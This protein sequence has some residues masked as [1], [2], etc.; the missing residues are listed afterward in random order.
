MHF[1]VTACN[2][3][4]KNSKK[5]LYTDFA[6]YSSANE[7]SDDDEYTKFNKNTK[8]VTR[9]RHVRN[10]TSG[11]PYRQPPPPPPDRAQWEFMGKPETMTLADWQRY[12][13]SEPP[14][15]L[16]VEEAAASATLALQQLSNS[17]DN[18]DGKLMFW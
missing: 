6:E 1:Q 3:V 18:P 17:A 11:C 15:G 10:G 12:T 13:D 16:V 4:F 2:P 9:S 5:A 7:Q 14:E 8:Y